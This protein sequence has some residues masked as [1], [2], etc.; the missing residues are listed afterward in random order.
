MAT[1]IIIAAMVLATFTFILE[2]INLHLIELAAI[3]GQWETN[4]HERIMEDEQ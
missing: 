3:Q 4:W 2:A 1:L